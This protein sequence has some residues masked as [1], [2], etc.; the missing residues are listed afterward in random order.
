MS[1]ARAGFG[2]PDNAPVTTCWSVSVTALAVQP[3]PVR[4][5]STSPSQ[6]QRPISQRETASRDCR[7]A[8]R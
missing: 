8:P 4:P 3:S 7:D 5:Q 2:V 6:C 1:H